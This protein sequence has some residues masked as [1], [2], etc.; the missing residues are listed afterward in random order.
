MKVRAPAW[1]AGLC[2]AACASPASEPLG[3]P[4]LDAG[5]QH[6]RRVFMLHCHAC[7]PS[8]GAGLAPGIA[9]KPLPRALVR[10]QVRTGLGAMP[11]FS[12]DELPPGDLDALL[13]YVAALRRHAAAGG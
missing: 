10:L 9:D 2:A 8:G 7:H 3:G 11:A 5:E 13:D 6:G 4:A 1:L 12:E